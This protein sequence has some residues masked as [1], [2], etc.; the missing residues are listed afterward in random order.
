MVIETFGTAPPDASVA[1]P[2]IVASWA[3]AWE[4]KATRSRHAKKTARRLTLC[5]FPPQRYLWY[6]TLKQL[7]PC[8]P[9]HSPVTLIDTLRGLGKDR[10]RV[11]ADGKGRYGN[12]LF[13]PI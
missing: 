2:T 11:R 3:N 12:V 5:T 10:T 7:A 8:T 6:Q 4:L 9:L 13:C 1:V